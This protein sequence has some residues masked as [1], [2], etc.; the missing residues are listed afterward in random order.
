MILSDYCD[1]VREALA[2]FEALRRL[3]FEAREIF[4]MPPPEGRE[5]GSS[6]KVVLR[7]QGKQWIYN[8]GYVEGPPE[9]RDFQAAAERWNSDETPDAER[10]SLYSSSHA[11]RHAVPMI[12]SI[13]H[14]G[15]MI[16]QMPDW[17]PDDE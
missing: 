15:I 11:G 6:F 3:G 7:T 5:E 13:L 17:L 1:A 4:F 8:G 16:P 10:E 12:Q 2:C 9:K 14:V